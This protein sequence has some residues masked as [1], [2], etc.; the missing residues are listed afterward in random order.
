MSGRIFSLQW[1]NFLVDLAEIICQELAT[2]SAA[3]QLD[4]FLII[5]RQFTTLSAFFFF[6]SKHCFNFQYCTVPKDSENF[7]TDNYG[8]GRL[9]YEIFR[10]DT[11]CLGGH[12]YQYRNLHIFWDSVLT[13]MLLLKK[14]KCSNR[15]PADVREPRVW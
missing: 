3:H 9:F 10:Y 8:A 14:K 4:S 13:L 1:P 2:L 7:V 15:M 12:S 6:F 11:W 5:E